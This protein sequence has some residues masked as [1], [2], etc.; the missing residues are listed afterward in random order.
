RGLG[1]MGLLPEEASEV[2]F[3]ENETNYE[4]LFGVPNRSPWVKDGFHRYL[5][6]GDAGAVNPA[7]E[8]TKAALCYRREL[9]SEETWVV[10]L[11]LARSATSPEPLGAPFDEI[12]QER[13]CETDEFYNSVT[14]GSLTEDARNVQRQAFAGMLWSKQFYHYVV[15]EWLDGDPAGP[16][17]PASRKQGRNKEWS[18]LYTDDVLSL[19]DKWEFPWFAAWDLAFHCIPLALIDPDFAKHQLIL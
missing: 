5:V 18:F 2:L 7:R 9:A 17:P 4:R 16:P 12:F 14:P 10:K 3:T 8:G 6:Q 11:R 1:P 13:Q 19:P 15:Q